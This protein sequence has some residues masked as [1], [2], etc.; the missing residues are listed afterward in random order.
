MGNFF[1]LFNVYDS[2]HIKK[3]K[4]VSA[5]FTD[6]TRIVINVVVCR[7]H[8]GEGPYILGKRISASIEV[9]HG[10]D[11]NEVEFLNVFDIR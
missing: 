7:N 3:Y 1:V 9:K 4:N 11:Y 10:Y 2:K 8:L 5:L 6:G